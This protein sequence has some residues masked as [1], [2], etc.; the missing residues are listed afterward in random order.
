MRSRGLHR[1]AHEAPA[2]SIEHYRETEETRP[3]QDVR[4]IGDA[5]TIGRSGVELRLLDRVPDHALRS[6]TVV[7]A[8]WR[9][10]TPSRHALAISRAISLCPA[11]IPSPASSDVRGAPYVARAF[12]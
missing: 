10:L 3:G 5:Q 2:E 9:Q 11:W 1:P 8:H 6:R 12:L 4:D 7:L